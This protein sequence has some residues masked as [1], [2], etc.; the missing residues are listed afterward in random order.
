M[1]RRKDIQQKKLIS[2]KDEMKTMKLSDISTHIEELNIKKMLLMDEALQSGDPARIIKARN[3][4][5]EE[6]QKFQSQ[7]KSYI[8]D[9]FQL[10]DSLG[11]RGTASQLTFDTLRQ[12]CSTPI[13]RAVVSTRVEQV[14]GFTTAQETSSQKAGWS[15]RRKRKVFA[16]AKDGNKEETTDEDKRIIEQLITFIM[17]GGTSAQEWDADD[18]EGFMRKITKDSL[19]LDQS[20]FEIVDNYKG[21][22]TEFFATD[23]ATYRLSRIHK[24]NDLD[25]PLPIKGY[26]PKYVQ[27][28]QGLVRSEF[29]PWELN[30]GIRNQSTDIRRNGYG[31]AEAEE[32]IRIITWLLNTDT[33]NGNFFSVGSSPKGLLK[34]KAGVNGD[35]LDE[36]RQSW[37]QQV[38][39]VKNSWKTPVLNADEV[40]WI[41]L[42][43]S[44]NDMEFTAFQEY[45]IKVACAIF[46][47]DPSEIGFYLSGNTG[48]APT[49]EGNNEYKLDFSRDKG[50][51]PLMRAQ[52]KW[53]NKHIVNRIND[54]FE[55]YWT[56]LENEDENGMLDMDI[57][58]LANGGMSMEDFFYKYSGRKFDPKYDTILNAIYVSIK[59]MQMAG[60]PQSNDAIDQVT[61]DDSDNPFK[62][63]NQVD[64]DNNPFNNLI[65]QGVSE[66]NPFAKELAL[67]TQNSFLNKN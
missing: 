17:E 38:A 67:H 15:I 33:Y 14:A 28:Y 43:K 62:M 7:G 1:T 58:K 64:K 57:K 59:Q 66:D 29:Y 21:I 12:M 16:S 41:D 63:Q 35:K 55:F 2:Y 27:L 42:Q 45:L 13:I 8:F 19:E 47:I 26:Y 10:N 52:Q 9:P 48:Q 6:Q 54:Q 23:G 37:I 53:I 40:D 65:K 30:F 31:S 18:F 24:E 32:L 60:N 56:G 25:S 5:S 22:P 4:W 61:E 44:N 46:K 34:V 39:G 3:L 51:K 49:Y 11:Y 20:T 36:F 50:L